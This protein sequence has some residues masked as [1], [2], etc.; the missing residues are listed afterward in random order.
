MNQLKN[1]ILNEIKEKRMDIHTGTELLGDISL[2]ED[3]KESIAIIGMSLR[4]PQADT[5]EEFH[6]NLLN[7]TDSVR[8]FPV[9]RRDIC[10]NWL[11]DTFCET[12][13]PYQKQGYLNDVSLFD[14][15]FF[16]LST[17]EAKKIHPLQRLFMLCAHE[18]IEDAGYGGSSLKNTKTAVLVGN[19]Q[20]GEPRY[21]EFSDVIDGTAFVGSVN[22]MMPSRIAYFLDLTGPCMVIDSACA[23]GLL[24]VHMACELLRNKEVD[25]AMVCGAALNLMPLVTERIEMLESP[26]YVVSPFDEKANGTVWGEGV[27]VVVLKRESAALSDGD[28]IYAAIKGNGTNNNGKASSL[29]V[30]DAQA[31]QNLFVDVWE[32]YGID[33]QN[34]KY[35]EAH[36]TGTEIGDAIEVKSLTKAFAAKTN[37][38]QFCAIGASKSNIGHMIGASGI[39]S[40]IK[41]AYAV[42]TGIIPPMQRFFSPSRHIDFTKGPLYIADECVVLDE[43]DENVLVG[44]N[45]FGINGTNVHMVLERP[46]KRKTESVDSKKRIPLFLS[47]KSEDALSE[48][49]DRYIVLLSGESGRLEDICYTAW[50][51]RGHYTNRIS[52]AASDKSELCCLLEKARQVLYSCEEMPE[53]CYSSHNADRLSVRDELDQCCREYALGHQ[54]DPSVYFGKNPVKCTIPVYPFQL[55]RC[56]VSFPSDKKMD[57]VIG[58]P[59]LINANNEYYKITLDTRGWRMNEYQPAGRKALPAA[60]LIEIIYQTG[61]YCYPGEA[62]QIGGL[63]IFD[64][65]YADMCKELLTSV[66]KTV[67]GIT[68]EISI[69]EDSVGIKTVAR[70]DI[71]ITTRVL[72]EIILPELVIQADLMRNQMKDGRWNCVNAFCADDAVCTFDVNL[73]SRY[74]KDLKTH[75]LHPAL[76][77]TAL[78]AFARAETGGMY[79]PAAWDNMT[80]TRPLPEH[81]RVIVKRISEDTLSYNLKLYDNQGVIADIEN[82]V[83]QEVEI[84]SLEQDHLIK[85]LAIEGEKKIE[86]F[87]DG[88]HTLYEKAVAAV[89]CDVLDRSRIDLDDEYFSLGGDSIMAITISNRLSEVIEK[90]INVEAFFAYPTIRMLAGFLEGA[91]DRSSVIEPTD[92]KEAYPLSAEQMG[93][94]MASQFNLQS[95]MYNLTAVMEVEGEIDLARIE[96]AFSFIVNT[97]ESFR[98]K[99]RITENGVEQVICDGFG[100]K[101]KVITSEGKVSLEQLQEYIADFNSPFD[102]ESGKLLRMQL[103]T[104]ADSHGYLFVGTHHIA[105]DGRSMMLLMDEFIRYYLTGE[106]VKKKLTYKDYAVFSETRTDSEDESRRIYWEALIGDEIPVLDLP[107]DYDRPAVA[108]DRGDVFEFSIDK[109]TVQRI[110]DEAA[111]QGITP[112][113]LMM[114]AFSILLSKYSGQSDIVIGMPFAGRKQSGLEDV[115]GMFVNTL[116]IR[117][118]V[119]AT[120]SVRQTTHDIHREYLNAIQYSE[121]S[122][123]RNAKRSGDG[124]MDERNPFYSV[125]FTFQNAKGNIEITDVASPRIALSIGNMQLK[126]I[127]FDRKTARSDLMLEV[128]ERA[129]DYICFF[130]YSTDLFNDSTPKRMADCFRRILE[131]MLEYPNIQIS[132][133]EIISDKEKSRVF[134]EFAGEKIAIA[135]TRGVIPAFSEMVK[136]Y[137]DKTAIVS[138]DN[139]YSYVELDELSGKIAAILNVKG[140][141]PEQPVMLHIGRSALLIASILGVWKQGASYI[142]VDVAYPIERVSRILNISSSVYIITLKEN[143]STGFV[144][145]FGDRLLFLDEELASFENTVGANVP[146]DGGRLAYTIFTSGS[147]GEPKGAMI[148]HAGMTNH[149]DAKV[150]ELHMNHETVIAANASPCFDISVWQFF[151]SLTV[152]GTVIVFS[153]QDTDDCMMFIKKVVDNRI[154]I[155]EIVPGYL[156]IMLDVLTDM[157]T[158]LDFLRYMIVTGD[159]VSVGLV[160]RWLDMYP[161]IPVVNAY[162]PT[163]AADDITHCIISEKLEATSVP[164]GS[165]IQNLNIYV[166]GDG[167][168]MC[169]IGVK[170]EICVSGIGVGRGYMNSPD[171]TAKAFSH[172]PF[173]PELGRMYRT[174]DLGAWMDNGQLKIYGRKDYQVKIR[175]FRIELGE[176]TARIE[177]CLNVSEV[178][179]VILDDGD[180]KLICGYYTSSTGNIDTYIMDQLKNQLPYYMIPSVL[181]YLE[182]MPHNANGKID[183]KKLPEPKFKNLSVVFS[184]AETIVEKAICDAV[185]KTFNIEKVNMNENFFNL[186]GDS[187]KAILFSAKLRQSGYALDI[188]HLYAAQTFSELALFAEAIT[189]EEETLSIEEFQL[190]PMQKKYIDQYQM[191]TSYWNQNYAVK[192]KGRMNPVQA[193][194]ALDHVLTAHDTLRLCFIRKGREWMQ[195]YRKDTTGCAVFQHVAEG[196]GIKDFSQYMEEMNARVCVNT[197]VNVGCLIF[198]GPDEDIAAFAVSHLVIDSM[199]FRVMVDDFFSTYAAIAAGNEP[200]EIS[201][202]SSYKKFVDVSADLFSPGKPCDHIN[203]YEKYLLRHPIRPLLES[204]QEVVNP[205]LFSDSAEKTVILPETLT[206]Y[207]LGEANAAYGTKTDQLLLCGLAMALEKIYGQ[208]CFCVFT[209]SDLRFAELPLVDL[210]RS[211][212]W[213]AAEYPIICDMKER[214]VRD[215]VI[216]IKEG[217]N[218]APWNGACYAYVSHRLAKSGTIF[219][220]EVMFNYMGSF[221][222]VHDGPYSLLENISGIRT[223][224]EARMIFGIEVNAVVIAKKVRLE[225]TYNSKKIDSVM[226]DRLLNEMETAL[227]KIVEHCM[228]QDK[229]VRTPS[230]YENIDIGM[231]ELSTI[232]REE[233]SKM[234]NILQICP[235][236][237]SQQGMLFYWLKNPATSQYFEQFAIVVEGD[238]DSSKL[239]RCYQRLVDK[240][241]V[242]RTIFVCEKVSVP[243]QIVL[244]YRNAVLKVVDLTD[245]AVESR[246]KECDIFLEEDRINNFDLT[247]DILF[248]IFLV[249]LSY[250][251]HMII[252]SFHHIILDGWSFGNVVK[253]FLAYYYEESALSLTRVPQFETYI[254]WCE[255]RSK[256]MAVN[257]LKEYL[258]GIED[259]TPLLGW[260]DNPEN[261]ECAGEQSFSLQKQTV[262]ALRHFCK[263]H[264]VTL[265]NSIAAVILRLLQIYN[266]TESAVVG[267]VV[268]GRRHEIDGINEMVGMLINSLPLRGDYKDGKT[269]VELMREVGKGIDLLEYNS[270]CSLAELQ[271]RANNGKAF[272]DCVIAFENYPFEETFIEMM[273]NG[274]NLPFKVLE[275]SFFEQTNYSCYLSIFPSSDE[276]VFRTRF[277]EAVYSQEDILGFFK[278]IERAITLLTQKGNI[279]LEDFTLTD[280][281]ELEMLESIN[282][283]DLTYDRADHA[284][285]KLEQA[286]REQ[287]DKVAIVC[288]GNMLDYAQMNLRANMVAKRLMENGLSIGEAVG[289]MMNRTI[290]LPV[291]LFGIMKAGGAYVPLQPSLPVDRLDAMIRDSA[292]RMVVANTDTG[293]ISG[294]GLEFIDIRELRDDPVADNPS[295]PISETDPA[296]ILYTS[297]TTGIPKGVIISHGALNN[298]I[299]AMENEIDFTCYHAILAPTTYTFDIFG[300]EIYMSVSSRLKIVLADDDERLNPEKLGFL[301]RNHGVDVV[302]MTPSGINMLIS[303]DREDNALREVRCILVG[304]EAVS[305][306]LLAALKRDSSAR[307]YNVYGP[308]E[309][310]IWSTVS[311]LTE[312]ESIDIGHPIANTQIYVLG[313]KLERLP[314]SVPGELFIGGDGVA[315]GYLNRPELNKERFIPNPYGKGKI[316]KTGDIVKL[317]RKIELEF[318]GRRDGQIKIRGFRIECEEVESVMSSYPKVVA[319]A[320]AG[321]KDQRGT[322]VLVGY[323]VSHEAIDLKL[324]KDHITSKLPEYMIPSKFC[325]IPEM[326][327]TSSGKINRKLLPDVDFDGSSTYI[328]PCSITEKNLTDIW[329]RVFSQKRIG[330]TDHFFEIGGHSLLATYLI[331]EISKQMG[332]QLSVRDVFLYPTISKMAQHLERNGITP[333]EVTKVEDGKSEYAV[334][335]SQKRFYLMSM[336]SNESSSWH[337]VTC[338]KSDR[339][340]NLKRLGEACGKICERHEILRTTFHMQESKIVQKI[341]DSIAFQIDMIQVGDGDI[342]KAIDEY[343]SMRYDLDKLFLFRIGVLQVDDAAILV[344][345]MHHIISDGISLKNFL[346]ELISFYLEQPV[347]TEPVQYKDFVYF[348]RELIQSEGYKNKLDFWRNVFYDVQETAYIMPDFRRGSKKTYAGDLIRY[349]FH[350]E[351]FERITACINENDMTLFMFLSTSLAVTVFLFTEKSDVVLGTPVSGRLHGAFLDSQGIFINTIPLLYRINRDESISTLLRRTRDLIINYFDNQDVV[352]EDIVQVSGHKSDPDRN[353]LFD[354][355][356]I[357]QNTAV[358]D[359]WKDFD[360]ISKYEQKSKITSSDLLLETEIIDGELWVSLG[361]ALALYTEETARNILDVFRKVVDFLTDRT[362]ET[363]GEIKLIENDDSDFTDDLNEDLS[364]FL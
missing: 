286:A 225:L 210:S 47:A 193:E 280:E 15:A 341:H 99:Y 278:H 38:K 270:Y 45:S 236:T 292:M 154:D 196:K 301:I 35:I 303:K 97:N 226:A 192:M 146:Y 26:D 315:N 243:V 84:L 100:C 360:G 284:F 23:S 175:G 277:N 145:E 255:K 160:N 275:T 308:T 98:T 321:R 28:R 153:D 108:T 7:K 140:I 53:H 96:R 163:E 241:D 167:D 122:F 252:W 352:F 152:G 254:K 49:I 326:P 92:E 44:V 156:L 103:L 340:F 181:M 354:I 263:Q 244:A 346:N 250:D 317:N 109:E 172:D 266:Q 229:N 62:L 76:L 29:T 309:T 139:T 267:N 291:V 259:A 56:W 189:D 186:G 164:V 265:Y 67:N 199:S 347:S 115:I 249:R 73:D 138:D 242:F 318:V 147:T 24:G 33:P 2:R 194:K 90:N 37:K 314:V 11:P 85:K 251:K 357:M 274:G 1:Y 299:I 25:Y 4:F 126:S 117:V 159:V 69:S 362:I 74:W 217:V 151:S 230:D 310:T 78:C 72:P 327:M 349:V 148:E 141:L 208:G 60:A 125:M 337:M 348:Q 351:E 54:V 239:E 166:L 264:N 323:Y 27:G 120:A 258:N 215:A 257:V 157:P 359:V 350:P 218:S 202:S 294:Y 289:V 113:A 31:Q 322:D 5:L 332:V 213:F 269:F 190:S 135:E 114:T 329:K 305:K 21:K 300:L 182:E 298:F 132:D 82:C 32:R 206:N 342:D 246:Q 363:V 216:S 64:T 110:K 119:P 209:E 306:G 86:G 187:V 232:Q 205:D 260:K 144:E 319:A 279:L 10:D 222:T 136:E 248:R 330:I 343:T 133:M 40:L 261:I 63:I 6:E 197:R 223:G 19:A 345:D 171:Q 240:Y 176:I 313:P 149:I 137:P 83:L 271:S 207:L 334:S 325:R 105:A 55:S 22:S 134:T 214:S 127:D 36:G 233:L 12:E 335:S 227:C 333:M 116:P 170:G 184:E 17:A 237:S 165:T 79:T 183:R 253:E 287:P 20:L 281:H 200:E 43:K 143:I 57:P 41:V 331:A 123:T 162:G 121:Y 290:D 311:E 129:G 51:G 106:V 8:E 89:W 173:D 161:D 180:R 112:G 234:G 316:Y 18:A 91:R 131:K 293:M 93:I 224:A 268:S 16:G 68:V 361:Y 52:A 356:Y 339:I 262:D 46:G 358:S 338:V 235:L 13:K 285:R 355:T 61:V 168:K 245:L 312:K 65:V 58:R 94:F 228:Q 304:G 177:A 256:D 169:P 204:T 75:M 282:H 219:P 344:I 336:A 66:I 95:T 188:K 102:L 111:S 104:D 295:L 328:P 48:L 307:I 77:D 150:R 71:A 211:V 3:N 203:Y 128:L 30:L 59:L 124:R 70:A 14:E 247:K 273:N 87:E 302:Q 155:L 297:G 158:R 81:F 178:V 272:F 191:D 220:Q 34:I 221:D 353:P 50:S 42:H 283:T 276:I 320:V 142:P 201:K 107:V 185:E 364:L 324:L 195:C 130:E 179:T 9:D 174:G 39:A 101:M 296:Y 118:S 80:I 238:M 198:S 231:D 288:G 212:G 88:G